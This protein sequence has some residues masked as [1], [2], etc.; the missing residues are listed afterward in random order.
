MPTQRLKRLQ[1]P[2]LQ[3]LTTL[4][5]ELK[6][7]APEFG[8]AVI[9]LL[10]D[11]KVVDAISTRAFL[12]NTDEA[13]KMIQGAV[14]RKRVILPRL[15][16][17]RKTRIAIVTGTDKAV[18]SAGR[19]IN[20]DKSAPKI[21]DAIYG[22]PITTDGIVEALSKEGT[23]IGAKVKQSQELRFSSATVAARL[24]RFKA[25]FNIAPMFKDD[26]FDV[27]A[28]DA[29]DSSFSSCS[30]SNDK[31]RCTNDQLKHLKQSHDIGKR[32]EM[33]KGIWGSYS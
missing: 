25:K 18:T 3:R 23:E 24:D 26:K 2:R 1:A 7:L 8:P 10:Q 21:M 20:I 32:K 12:E 6:V 13:L 15:D 31:A 33:V 22:A 4:R 5:D 16:K 27:M 17:Q 30:C 28:K 29:S 11:N 19:M 14:G 9:R